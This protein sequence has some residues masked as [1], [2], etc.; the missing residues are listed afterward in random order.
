MRI[1]G[2]KTVLEYCVNILM[3]IQGIVGEAIDEPIIINNYTITVRV[4]DN[5]LT[6]GVLED[7]LSYVL[8]AGLIFNIVQYKSSSLSDLL[9][10]EIV[11]EDGDI[12]DEEEPYSEKMYIGPSDT[13]PIGRIDEQI[14]E[15]PISKDKDYWLYLQENGLIPENTDGI[16]TAYAYDSE[17]N[18]ITEFSKNTTSDRE[19]SGV[20]IKPAKDVNID[21]KKITDTFVYLKSDIKKEG[22]VIYNEKWEED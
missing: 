4:P 14:I 12:T 11:Y 2:T 5:L 15:V 21:T 7:L 18:L 8:P 9:R 20:I 19:V 1:K 3:K 10:T 17:G 6:L 16:N 13:V 22:K